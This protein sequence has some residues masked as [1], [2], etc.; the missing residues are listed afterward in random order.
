MNH[1]FFTIIVSAVIMASTFSADAQRTTRGKL[2]PVASAEKTSDKEIYDTIHISESDSL[3]F[4]VTGYE[5]TL[6]ATKESF[7]VTNRTDSTYDCLEF[8]I[9]YKDMNGRTLDVRNVK[10]NINLP[11]GATRR[12]DTRSW[13]SQ[14]VFYYHRSPQPRASHATPY[15]VNIRAV[16]ALRR[17]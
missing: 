12:V 2:K 4:P 3:L 16:A 13:D 11:A 1:R 14:N 15:R 17:L 9:T 8:V 7:F 10:A 5:K 6:R